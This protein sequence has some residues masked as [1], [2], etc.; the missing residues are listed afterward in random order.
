MYIMISFGLPLGEKVL[1]FQKLIRVDMFS[2]KI[3][4]SFDLSFSMTILVY[5]LINLGENESTVQN[6]ISP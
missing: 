2:F 3:I 4:A 1:W 5:K 6:Q